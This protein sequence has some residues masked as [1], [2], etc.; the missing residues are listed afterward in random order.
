LILEDYGFTSPVELKKNIEKS[1]NE[2]RKG[3]DDDLDSIKKK[4][5]GM[6]VSVDAISDSLVGVGES[7]DDIE[8]R[9][10]SIDI[11]QS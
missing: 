7:L 10:K 2:R 11:R 8:E 6:M 5:V 1:I 4:V 3:I 9:L